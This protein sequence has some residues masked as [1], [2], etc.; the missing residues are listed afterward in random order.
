[1]NTSN[2][3]AKIFEAL[4]ST[5]RRLIL[6]YLAETTLTSGQIAERFEMT[7]PALTK[8]LKLL[9]NAGLVRSEKRG[10]YV[11]YSLSEQNLVNTLVN[12][13]ANFC[14]Q[15]SPLKKESKRI[16][17]QKSASETDL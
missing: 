13:A 1:M 3:S 14:P 6:S 9:E 11:H 12:F 15:G 8:H 5:P 7:R 2:E 4:S 16:S 17:E 10:Q